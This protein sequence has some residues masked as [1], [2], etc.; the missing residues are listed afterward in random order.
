MRRTVIMWALIL[1]LGIVTAF[2]VHAAVLT[3]TG[4][5]PDLIS[6]ENLLAIGLYEDAPGSSDA[7]LIVKLVADGKI[8]IDEG[9]PVKYIEPDRDI[10]SKNDPVG[11][12]MPGFDESDWEEGIYGVG[13]GDNDDNTIVGSPGTTWSIYTRAYFDVPN[14]FDVKTLTLNIDYDD[15]VVVWLNG[16]LA[17]RSM[18]TELP[19]IPQWND[20]CGEP[21]SHEA[22]KQD[23][24]RYESVELKFKAT[25]AVDPTAA[26]T[27]T[28]GRIKAGIR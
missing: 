27:M 8:L 17:A 21:N 5:S 7:T 1:G 10:P 25:T 6:G 9:S 20:Q 23:P 19:E 26:F 16:I 14:A 28:W 2:H 12:A 4:D 24:P 22:S 11:W 3:A 15:S 18:P 13:Y